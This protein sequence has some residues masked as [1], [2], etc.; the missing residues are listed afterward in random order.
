[1]DKNMEL[2]EILRER[3][4]LASRRISEICGEETVPAPF[5]NFF[6]KTAKFLA[7][8][9]AW[10]ETLESG[11]TE[12][13]TLEQWQEKNRALYEDLSLIHI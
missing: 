11:E 3:Y 2:D 10:K 12:T 1:M 7:Q 8:M 13:Y 9:T 4:C 6:R 5:Y